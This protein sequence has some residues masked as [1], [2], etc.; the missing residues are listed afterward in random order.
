MHLDGFGQSAFLR[1][2]TG[3]AGNDRGVKSARDKFFYSDDD[4]LL[5]ALR[6]GDD[7]YGFKATFNPP[8]VVPL[9]KYWLDAW[10]CG[11]M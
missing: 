8:M 2:V 4:G 11:G 6:Q 1:T 5:V 9:G 7:K 3:I 10:L